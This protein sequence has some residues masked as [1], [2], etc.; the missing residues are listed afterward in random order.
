MLSPL[1]YI[2]Q[3]FYLWL[4]RIKGE[5]RIKNIDNHVIYRHKIL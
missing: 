1:S 2:L 3:K 4:D 5:F